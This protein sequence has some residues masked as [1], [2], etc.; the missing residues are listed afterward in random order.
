MLGLFDSPFIPLTSNII[1]NFK[2]VTI[3]MSLGEKHH[4]KKKSMNNLIQAI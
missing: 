1:N 2:K 3:L 4:T